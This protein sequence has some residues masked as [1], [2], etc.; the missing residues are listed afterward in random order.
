[1][2]AISYVLYS[3]KPRKISFSICHISNLLFCL[4]LRLVILH[5]AAIIFHCFVFDLIFFPA[6][7]ILSHCNF[8]YISQSFHDKFTK[9]SFFAV[10]VSLCL[11]IVMGSHLANTGVWCGV[12]TNVQ[13][14]VTAIPFVH[15][16][17]L[18]GCLCCY[19]AH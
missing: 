17:S 14:L 6:F 4:I 7:C 10:C 8:V 16:K 11:L 15:T 9:S 18:I 12:C 3:T 19:G 1:M 13:S 2:R 5:F